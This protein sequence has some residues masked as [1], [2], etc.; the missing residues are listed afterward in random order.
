MNAGAGSAR[1]RQR[2]S[3]RRVTYVLVAAA[4]MT[5]VH[6]G[7]EPIA[8]QVRTSPTTTNSGGVWTSGQLTYDLVI[9][10]A[11]LAVDVLITVLLIERLAKRRDEKRWRGAREAALA[12]VM[13]LTDEILVAVLPPGLTVGG[14]STAS[15]GAQVLRLQLPVDTVIPDELAAAVEPI[16]SVKLPIAREAA[17]RTMP[18]VR[19][20]LATGE[21]VVGSQLHAE[22]AL[23]ATRLQDVA[24][25]PTRFSALAVADLSQMLAL[26]AESA[27]RAR[28]AASRGGVATGS[29]GGS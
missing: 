22:L 11:L 28:S 12:E 9:G 1:R 18:R 2:D 8:A 5:S 7:A 16:I 10:L 4:T 13:Y 6:L 14:G 21:H 19:A 20:L 3:T 25:A 24:V 23:F 26:L 17:A 27:H 15:V 29:K